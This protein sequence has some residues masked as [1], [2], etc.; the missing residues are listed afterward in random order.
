MAPD[1]NSTR[2]SSTSVGTV[3][4]GLSLR[5]SGFFWSPFWRLMSFTSQGTPSS[6]RSQR[7]RIE[8]LCGEWYSVSIVGLLLAVG[9][10][11]GEDAPA[12]ELEQRLPS[13]LGHL[14]GARGVTWSPGVRSRHAKPRD[15]PARQRDGRCSA[16]RR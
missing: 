1:S 8:R 10:R 9:E 12:P 14:D 11:R 4:F 15:V 16:G 13:C 5:Y 3:P 7:G 2:S 6:S